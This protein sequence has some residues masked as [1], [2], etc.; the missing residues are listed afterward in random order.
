MG[1]FQ[2]QQ[3]GGDHD[4]L[5]NRD[6][7]SIATEFPATAE[8]RSRI[9][10]GAPNAAAI[11]RILHDHPRARNEIMALIHKTLG[12]GFAMEVAAENKKIFQAEADGGPGIQE[13]HSPNKAAIEETTA[14]VFAPDAAAGKS[15][16]PPGAPAAANSATSD[17]GFVDQQIREETLRQDTM[18]LDASPAAPAAQSKMNASNFVGKPPSAE[19]SAE[20]MKM[21][22][23]VNG[24]PAED[25]A[26]ASALG[27]KDKS[28]HPSK[29]LKDE[30]VIGASSD[31]KLGAPRDVAQFDMT[32][33][34]MESR[35]TIEGPAPDLTSTTTAPPTGEVAKSYELAPQP[36]QPQGQPA[37]QHGHTDRAINSYDASREYRSVTSQQ[38]GVTVERD[39]NESEN[40][41]AAPAAAPKKPEAK[42]VTG[43][44]RYNRAHAGQVAEFLKATGNACVDESGEADPHKVARWQADHGV[45]PDGRV[46]EQ[47]ITAAILDFREPTAAPADGAPKSP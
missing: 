21:F 47:T 38:G 25:A 15:E 45:A 5:Q 44:R 34:Y 35:A 32:G 42:W 36:D 4:D 33:E 3:A 8:V 14:A 26:P 19:E 1:D 20:V 6:A 24:M 31:V 23:E 7:Q 41:D 16:K 43:A 12:N 17:V 11:A 29:V 22:R 30:T 37:H 28:G 39:A 18:K 2:N 13:G 10:S 46:G 9:E 27:A 40:S